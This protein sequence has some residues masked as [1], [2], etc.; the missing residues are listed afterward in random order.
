MP[1]WDPRR[2]CE[3]PECRL[4]GPLVYRYTNGEVD[5]W[6]CLWHR[7]LVPGHD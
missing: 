3:T 5:V 6:M 7:Y 4:R 1:F 2:R